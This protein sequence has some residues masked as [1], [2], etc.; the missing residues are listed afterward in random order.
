MKEIKTS[1]TIETLLE[2]ISAH[3]FIFLSLIVF[4]RHRGRLV[5]EIPF[6]LLQFNYIFDICSFFL[7]FVFF[8]GTGIIQEIILLVRQIRAS[9]T[10]L[11]TDTVFEKV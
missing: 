7:L 1:I 9:E 11:T 2:I 3:I 4:H 5:L 10:I 6:Y 8:F